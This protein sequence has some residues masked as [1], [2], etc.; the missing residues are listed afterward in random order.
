MNYTKQD[1]MDASWGR[2][3]G[4][5]PKLVE[6]DIGKKL[7]LPKKYG[8]ERLCFNTIKALTGKEVWCHLHG[9]GFRSQFYGE[10]VAKVWPT[11]VEAAMEYYRSELDEVQASGSTWQADDHEKKMQAALEAVVTGHGSNLSVQQAI[12]L[13]EQVLVD[14]KLAEVR[15]EYGETIGP[16]EAL[17]LARAMLYGQPTGSPVPNA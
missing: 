9:T 5:D 17:R 8:W 6:Q 16:E 4:I 11:L 1:W 10:E 13:A 2:G 7:K 14:E 12:E 15:A 3:K